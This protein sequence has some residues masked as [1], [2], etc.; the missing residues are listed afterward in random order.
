MPEKTEYRA[1][2]SLPDD[3][4]VRLVSPV[5]LIPILSAN[6]E[7]N[8]IPVT[9]DA[10][11]DTGAEVTCISPAVRDTLKLIPVETNG[12]STISGVGGDAPTE[13][14]LVSIRIIHNLE[15]EYC[16][17]Y[18]V[19]FK[20]DDFDMIIGMDIITMGDFAV[21]NADKKTSFSFA[22]PPFPDRINLAEKADKMNQQ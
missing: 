19:E 22:I 20:D 12:T 18:V 3:L 6:K 4:A 13:I 15:I 9:F 17:V 10:L 11:W 2:S 7:S 5:E 8:G 16:P 1:F 14:T 21:C